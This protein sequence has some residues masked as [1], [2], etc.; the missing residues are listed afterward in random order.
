MGAYEGDGAG[1][2]PLTSSAYVRTNGS[3]TAGDGSSANPWRT[4]GYALAQLA[5]GGALYV[6]GGTYAESVQFGPE[7]DAIVVRGGYDP[8]SWGWDPANQATVVDGR[9][10]PP[11]TIA[12]TADSNTLSCLT[13]K[14]GTNSAMAGILFMGPGQY[15]VVDGC[16]IVSNA[17]GIYAPDWSPWNLMLRNSVVAR[18]SA[19]GVYVLKPQASGICWLYNCTVADNGGD[20]YL[21][22]GN[23]EF[24]EVAPVAKNSLFTGNSGYGIRKTAG[25]AGASASFCLFY[26]NTSGPTNAT[27]NTG[28]AD[29]GNNLFTDPPAY[30]GVGAAPYLILKTSAALNSGTNLASLGVTQD[31]LGLPRPQ[32]GIYDR[33]AYERY[34]PPPG[35]VIKIR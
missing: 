2:G 22:T 24:L 30:E 14:N 18:N 33:G 13:L 16:T 15:V 20:G 19:Q 4:I 6:A 9:G 10:A 28:I 7:K 23:Q 17:C 12:P 25:G 26:G 3:D 34:V 1:E 11:V 27:G 29:L 8:V 35:T 21:V 31:I 5:P 32:G